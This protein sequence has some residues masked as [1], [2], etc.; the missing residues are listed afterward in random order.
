MGRGF[1]VPKQSDRGQWAKVEAL[2]QAGY[3]F[4]NHTGWREVPAYPER[5]REVDD[6]IRDNPDHPF[7]SYIGG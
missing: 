5:L 1:K 7:R 3:R 6:F 4:I 2:W